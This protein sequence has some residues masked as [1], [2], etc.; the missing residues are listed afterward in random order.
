MVIDELGLVLL[1]MLLV[2]VSDELGLLPLLLLVLPLL[3]T[4]VHAESASKKTTTRRAKD[5][6]L[7]EYK[8][9]TN[10]PKFLLNQPTVRYTSG[11]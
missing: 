4:P 1:L 8:K 9:D 3:P 7:N 5:F 11:S 6:V 10:V 2:A